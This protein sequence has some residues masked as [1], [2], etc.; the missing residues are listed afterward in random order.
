MLDNPKLD[1]FT[2][3]I[4]NVTD[5]WLVEITNKFITNSKKYY[6]DQQFFLVVKD[7]EKYID[8]LTNWYI[9]V[10]R[11]RFWKSDDEED[12]RV[13][14]WCL[15]TAIKKVCQ[16]MAPIIPFMTEHIWQNMCRSLEP[17][18]SESIILSDFPTEMLDIPSENLEEK[19]E[20]ARNIIALAQ[21]LRNE[22]QLK[23]KQPL[24]EMFVCA[25]KSVK[26]SVELYS[27][28]IKEELN[29]KT[30]VFEEN[31]ERFNE[32]FLTVN[33]K[34]AGQVLKGD[35]QKLKAELAK[36]SDSE[37]QKLIKAYDEGKVSVGEFKDLDKSL[38]TV[39]SKPKEEFVIMSDGGITVV[40]DITLDRELM[41]EGLYRELTRS[42][43]VL[44]KE[45]GFK[46][47][48]RIILSYKT[49]SDT[50]NEVIKTYKDKV[51]EEVLIKD[52]EK[53]ISDF[54]ID[55]TI[56]V[57]DEEIEIKMKKA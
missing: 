44:R 51:M 53:D 19:T 29:I 41:L 9:R 12:K 14:Y 5:K 6:D 20:I 56:S 22:N 16:V 34:T 52:I 49:E 11:R 55:K 15:Y 2:P 10:N 26:P 32:R 3:R 24:K 23:I 45:A 33:F 17:N 7:F 48:D 30:L 13:A 31:V 40:L 37:M 43:Q 21:R 28:I 1:G 42:A 38:F 54:A 27:D 18:S 4:T 35:V 36:V 50:L 25:D 46:V 47:E 39:S 57:G 8:D